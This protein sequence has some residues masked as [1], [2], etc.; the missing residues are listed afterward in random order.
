M[1]LKKGMYF[2]FCM[3]PF[4]ARAGLRLNLKQ[5]ETQVLDKVPELAQ[6]EAKQNALSQEAIADGQWTD[7][8]LILGAANIPINSFSFTQENM[9]QIQVGL[10]QKL[11]KGDSLSI[12]SL[13]DHLEV[14]A[15]KSQKV[16]MKLTILRSVRIS[17]LNA[18]YWQ[19]VFNIYQQERKLFNHLLFVNIKLLENNKIQQKDVIRVQFE[20]SQ[21]EQK[22]IL[23][24]QGLDSAKAM[25][26]RWIPN[27]QRRLSFT[28]PHWSPPQ[29]LNI[30]KARLKSQ[31]L[32][33]KDNE[34]AAAT[35]QGIRLA[36][37][38]YIPGVTVG[39]VYGIRQGR[40]M[41]SNIRSN[42]V[43]A[44][45]SMDLP[46]FTQNR[47]DR[48]LKASQERYTAALMKQAQDY[49][50]LN[51]KLLDNYSAWS[52]LSKQY[53]IYINRLCPEAKHYVEAV[54]VA[55]QNKYESFSTLARAYIVDYNTQLSALKIRVDMLQARVNL[56]YLEGK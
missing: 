30:L 35:Q 5:T 31:P 51:S 53:K 6:I 25:L 23:A 7:P 33:L 37:Q 21:L 28:L 48:H 24:R 2:L 11:P 47:Q 15:T 45:L 20:Q 29:A 41:A 55:Y 17:W 26:S 3:L 18:C 34:Q 49:R 14:S 16:L 13:Q 52:R 36:E 1:A 12:R 54:Q 39:V 10:M 56:L 50:I 43:G 38:Q 22:M 44:Q 19:K 40:D 27:Q 8:K 9:T 4:F 42:F 32:I 46:L